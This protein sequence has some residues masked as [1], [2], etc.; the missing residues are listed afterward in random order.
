MYDANT[1]K[2]ELIMMLRGNVTAEELKELRDEGWDIAEE[3]LVGDGTI[4]VEVSCYLPL[5]SIC[6]KLRK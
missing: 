6:R 2:E 3:E 5:I 1:I 4:D